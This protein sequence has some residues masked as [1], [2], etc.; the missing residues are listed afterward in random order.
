MKSLFFIFFS[1][2]CSYAICQQSVLIRGK[3][4]DATNQHP[5]AYAE[6]QCKG[7][8]SGA[9]SLEDGSF[10]FPIDK[11]LGKIKL[12]IRAI[13]YQTK[14]L[15]IGADRMNS[16]LDISLEI[17]TYELDPVWIIPPVQ[18]L[19]KALAQEEQYNSSAFQLEAHYR[20]RQIF[21]DHTESLPFFDIEALIHLNYKYGYDSRGGVRMPY[22]LKA[23]SFVPDTLLDDFWFEGFHNVAMTGHHVLYF[24]YDLNS[25]AFKKHVSLELE[26]HTIYDGRAVFVLKYSLEK[27]PGGKHNEHLGFMGYK[28][29]YFE[30][31][32]YVQQDNFEIL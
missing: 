23:R 6:I 27:P 3:L 28:A 8:S 11:P 9:T 19:E 4:T 26:K 16:P 7:S 18:I 2:I 5:I 1:C 31:R 14:E 15:E 22:I 30:G 32:I 24:P 21:P 25:R 12:V 17:A 29:Q 13:G 20:G 10:Q